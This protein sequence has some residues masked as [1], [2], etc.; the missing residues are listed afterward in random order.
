M[1]GWD[2]PVGWRVAGG[3]FGR[4]WCSS[5]VGAAAVLWSLMVGGPSV[6]Q[7]G[8]G[9]AWSRSVVDEGELWLWVW[10]I[11]F[12]EWRA[13]G[14]GGVWAGRTCTGASCTTKSL[15]KHGLWFAGG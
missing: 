1:G 11:S 6:R 2:R 4:R 8:A 9:A 7:G 13:V 15:W 3:G 12:F 14:M 5:G 10:K